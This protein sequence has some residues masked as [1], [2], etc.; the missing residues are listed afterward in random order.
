MIITDILDHLS[1][2]DW[3]PVL[4]KKIEGWFA[5]ISKELL[6]RILQTFTHV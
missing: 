3:R 6:T 1:E 5:M 4:C 2:A